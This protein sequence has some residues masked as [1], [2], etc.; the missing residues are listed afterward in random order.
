MPLVESLPVGADTAQWT[1]WG[2]VAR[3]VLTHPGRV[4]AARLL[5][6][7]QLDA[8]DAA[9]SRFRDDSELAR[10]NRGP[11]QARVSPLLAELV[12]TALDVAERTDGDVDPTVGSLLRRLGYDRD[13]AAI[14]FDSAGAYAAEPAPGW[15]T[16]RL[17]GDRLELPAGVELDL[18]ASAKAWA[19]DRCAARVAAE[20]DTGVMVGLGGDVAT[21]GPAP[22]GGWPILV[23]DRP[24]EPEC[25]IAIPAGA[26][27]ATSS[28]ISRAWAQ[29]ARHHIVDPATGMPAERVWRTVSVAA[30]S[31]VEANM[32]ST[33]AVIRGQRAPAWLRGHGVAAR[34]VD[35]AG[36]VVTV[37]GWPC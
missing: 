19:A 7:A 28:T 35:A 22:A 21:A 3:I 2:T 20:L 11:S 5:V 14:S 27:L 24:G 29:G 9:C 23:R 37:G 13:F 10:L 26:A 6:Q 15:R 25:T 12:A 4:A 32:L 17:D 31:C 1:V 18:G 16:V 34:L 30:R 8:V 36:R 33:A